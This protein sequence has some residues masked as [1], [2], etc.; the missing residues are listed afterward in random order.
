MY[1]FRKHQFSQ[2][3]LVLLIANVLPFNASVAR[4]IKMSTSFGAGVPTTQ[5][6]FS[7]PLQTPEDLNRSSLYYIIYPLRF[8][9][10]N[11]AN[12]LHLIQLQT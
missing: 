3:L 8:C 6:I 2:F 11:I 10:N 4:A 7:H 5:G 1:S 9:I 12:P